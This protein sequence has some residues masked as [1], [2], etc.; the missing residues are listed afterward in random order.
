MAK[1]TKKKRE[2][3]A[4]FQKK[5]LKVG[6][7]KAVAANSTDVNFKSKSIHVPTQHINSQDSTNTQTLTNILNA[8]NHHNDAIRQDATTQLKDLYS[9]DPQL[10]IYSI[11]KITQA[12]SRG[13]VDDSDSIRKAIFKFAEEYF[14]LISDLDMSPFFSVLIVYTGSAMTHIN[15]RIRLSGLRLIKLVCDKYPKLVSKYAGNL[16]PQFLDILKAEKKSN[17]KGFTTT[18]NFSANSKLGLLQSR[19]EVLESFYIFLS[20]LMDEQYPIKSLKKPDNEITYDWNSN[21]TMN[22]LPQLLLETNSTGLKLF[23]YQTREL[24]ESNKTISLKL[25]TKQGKKQFATTSSSFD[26]KSLV[27]SL[28]NFWIESSEILF[29]NADIVTSPHLKICHLVIQILN[30]VW[31]RYLVANSVPET[32]QWGKLIMQHIANRFPFGESQSC[33]DSTCLNTLVC[34]NLGFAKVML[35]IMES[36]AFEE[37]RLNV[38][39]KTTLFVTGLFEKCKTLGGDLN[40][41]PM[42]S[43]LTKSLGSMVNPD[44]QSAL[45]NS[46]ISFQ[47]NAKS[48][49]SSLIS[50]KMISSLIMDISMVDTSILKAWL[51][52]LPKQLWQLKLKDIELSKEI[53]LFLKYYLQQR[54]SE[55]AKNVELMKSI[56]LALSPCLVSILARGPIYGPFKSYP[57]DLQ[58]LFLDVLYYLPRWNDQLIRSL[59]FVCQD[60]SLSVPLKV[61]LLDSVTERQNDVERRLPEDTFLSFRLSV[62]L[63]TS[64]SQQESLSTKPENAKCYYGRVFISL[65]EATEEQRSYHKSILDSFQ[66]IPVVYTDCLIGLMDKSI[67]ILTFC[68]CAKLLSMDFDNTTIDAISKSSIDAIIL[69]R[70]SLVLG[71]MVKL[72]MEELLTNELKRHRWLNN[73]SFMCDSSIEETKIALQCIEYMFISNEV[74]LEHR[75]EIIT[76]F[77]N[78]KIQIEGKYR[79][80][81]LLSSG[82]AEILQS[83]SFSFK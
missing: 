64:A 27:P 37:V 67:S 43:G 82:V 79:K 35:S 58:T 53:L 42:A 46:M 51:L 73:L 7:G 83:V 26:L 16:L 81:D 25:N 69:V 76:H 44:Q 49:S 32:E 10:F 61:Y 71:D 74:A 4:D 48:A 60:T 20:L 21:D 75:K 45:L 28:V 41:L 31:T 54:D 14:D 23:G 47:M 5:K 2:K 22:D 66:P 1:S 3:Q 57:S 36:G 63:S 15:E 18:N 39:E 9:K 30:S 52:S 38:V 12:I 8:L 56:Q 11:D 55:I 17:S 40:F 80:E 68:K 62:L 29:G 6:K 70:N 33:R 13:F 34:M 65:N 77:K 24:S 59:V 50:F 72:A 78:L 19:D